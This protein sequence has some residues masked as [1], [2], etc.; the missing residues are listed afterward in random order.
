MYTVKQVAEK[1]DMNPHTVRFYTDNNLIP[2]LKRG[3]NNVRL[4][5][6]DAIGWLTGVKNLRDCGMSL[7]AIRKYVDLCLIGQ[8]A[9][10]ERIEIVREQQE[11][12][13]RELEKLQR[14]AT[15]LSDKLDFYDRLQK[16]E[17][18]YDKSNPT[19]WKRKKS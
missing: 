5:D 13:N 2:D 1:L 3:E 11:K 10:P 6:E 16:G 17:E 18:T 14:C 9:L 19:E 7:K 12:V 8:E 15:Y 4:F